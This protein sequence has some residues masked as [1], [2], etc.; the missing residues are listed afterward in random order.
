MGV[1]LVDDAATRIQTVV[2]AVI[3]RERFHRTA[4]EFIDDRVSV[5][6]EV[7]FQIGRLDDLHSIRKAYLRLILDRR[8]RVNLRAALAVGEEHIQ[9][10]TGGQRSLA[11]LAGDLDI[12]VSEA[13]RAVGILP[14]EDIPQHELLPRLQSEPLSR[15]LAFGM[16]EFFD[17]VDR[18]QSGFLIEI[19][20]LVERTVEVG[21]VASDSES[22]I[23]ADENL[24]GAHLLGIKF[25]GIFLNGSHIAITILSPRTRRS[26]LSGYYPKA[27][28]PRG[29]DWQAST[30]TRQPT[31]WHWR[32]LIRRL[33]V[34]G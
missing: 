20:S 15:P 34:W 21:V 28:P 22:D 16:F 24:A 10:D 26:R 5:W 12:S 33:C 8:G 4:F 25:G 31:P 9:P 27:K 14:P 32:V 2:R 6:R 17:E 23:L 29:C 7:V 18:T 3:R 11:V 13:A 30:R 1:K 19:P